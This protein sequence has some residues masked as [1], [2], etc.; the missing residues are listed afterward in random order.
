MDVTDWFVLEKDTN[1][2]KVA[3]SDVLKTIVFREDTCPLIFLSLLPL[4][5]HYVL[6][7]LYELYYCN[8][9]SNAT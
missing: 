9:S 7:K 5:F 4:A 6:N 2:I 3:C 1:Q 8:I